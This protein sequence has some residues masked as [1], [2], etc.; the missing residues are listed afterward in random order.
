ME[1]GSIWA[2][3]RGGYEALKTRPWL[4]LAVLLVI[5][6]G[7]FMLPNARPDLTRF[8]ADD[9]EAYLG[10]SY[11][12]THGLGYTRSLAA[13]F[14]VPHTTWPPGLP[15]LLAPVTVL[16]S[17]PVS[18]LMVKA[19]IIIIGLLGIVLAWLYVARVTR[20]PAAADLTAVALVLQP[21]YWLFSRMALTEVPTVVFVLFI[22]LLIDV[23]WSARTPT[24]WQAVAVGLISGLGMLLRGTVV[25]LI[26]VPLA[27]AAGTRRTKLTRLRLLW[28]WSGHAAGF[29]CV[30]IAWAARNRTIDPAGLGFDGINQMRMLVAVNPVDPASRLMDLRDIMHAFIDNVAHHI[31][32]NVPDQLLPGL[33]V[34]HWRDWQGAPYLAIILTTALA[35][36]ALPRRFTMM[37]LFVVL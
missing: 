15:I 1:A 24:V 5:A 8:N 26:F 30:F 28:L 36:M 14:Y 35:L 22:L 27:Y 4:R 6:A 21:F 29:C 32:Y 13:G 31:I 37:P 34:A 10:L 18:W 7:Y 2:Q 20:S 25:G 3:R 33:W 11:A 16:T 19:T 9:S 23:V 17:L 12:L